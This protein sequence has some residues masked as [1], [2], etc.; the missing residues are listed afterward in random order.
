MR[1]TLGKADRIKKGGEF[2]RVFREGRSAQDGSL[3]LYVL[4]N[5]LGRARLGVAASVR[6]GGAVRR[7]R[8]RRLCR[9]AFRTVRADLPSGY[10]Y[11]MVPVPGRPFTVVG[12]RTSLTSLAGRLTRA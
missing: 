11:V 2:S 8:L 7:T 1:Q 3:R 5:D 4:A 10:D 12:L 6:H 9:E